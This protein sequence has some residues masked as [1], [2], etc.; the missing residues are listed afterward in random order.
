MHGTTDYAHCACYS[1]NPR[2]DNLKLDA[3]IVPARTYRPCFY[4]LPSLLLRQE[5]FQN[6]HNRSVS[7]QKQTSAPQV[8]RITMAHHVFQLFVL[9]QMFGRT[10]A[11]KSIGLAFLSPHTSSVSGTL[12]GTRARTHASVAL[13]HHQSTLLQHL[14]SVSTSLHVRLRSHPRLRPGCCSTLSLPL[15]PPPSAPPLAEI[16]PSTSLL[17]SL[18]S[19]SP[20]PIRTSL[21]LSLSPLSPSPIR[22]SLFARARPN[23]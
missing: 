14:A 11:T 9:S 18:S 17:L 5:R 19:L 16:S 21:L 8:T 6:Q 7:E 12:Q 22:A 15:L 4:P 23:L 2:L 1:T 13:P 20:S 3:A 10:S